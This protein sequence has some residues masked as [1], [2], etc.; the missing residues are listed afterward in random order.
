MFLNSVTKVSLKIREDIGCDGSSLKLFL[1]NGDDQE[2]CYPKTKAE[3]DAG[4]LLEWSSEDLGDCS[5][6]NMI[7][8]SPKVGIIPSKSAT[9]F[10]PEYVTVRIGDN[11]FAARYQTFQGFQLV[12]QQKSLTGTSRSYIF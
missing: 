1:T 8:K 12:N 4:D 9:N 3:F 7:L 10:C 6:A 5:S 11:L 2:R